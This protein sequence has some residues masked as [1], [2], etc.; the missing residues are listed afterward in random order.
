MPDPAV[1]IIVVAYN[2]PREVPR[3]IRSLSMAMQVG[4]TRDVYEVILVD[5]GSTCKIDI[6]RCRAMDV[7]LRVEE[8]GPGEPSPCRAV[9]RGLAL[10]RGELCG[11]MIDGARL[12]SP[13]LVAGALRA[14]RLH[15]RPVISTLGFHLG[16]DVQMKTVRRGY[17]QNE[18]DRLLARVKWTEDG[19]RLFTISAFA[20]SSAGGWFAPLCE[21]NALFLPKDLWTELGGYDERFRSPGGGLANLDTYVRACALPDSQL[22]TLLGEGTFHQ[23]HGGVATNAAQGA[24]PWQAFHEEYLAIRGR[25]FVKP[26]VIPLFLGFV[27]RHVFRSIAMSVGVA[28]EACTED[29]SQVLRVGESVNMAPEQPGKTAMDSESLN[30]GGMQVRVCPDPVFIIGSPRSGTSALALALDRHSRLWTSAESDFL[31]YLFNNRQAE[32]AFAQAKHGPAQRW[33][34]QEGVEEGE[35]LACL[36]LG[37]NAL[38]TSRSRGRRWLDKSPLYTTIVDVLA[39]LFPGARFLHILRD[40]RRVVHSMIHFA[41]APGVRANKIPKGFIGGWT[42]NFREACRTWRRYVDTAMDFCACNP[43]RGLTVVNEKLLANTQ[44]GFVQICDFLTLPFEEAP[45]EYFRTHRHNSS[46]GRD[47]IGNLPVD[48]GPDPWLEWDENQQAIFLEEAGPTMLRHGLATVQELPVP[49][50]LLPPSADWYSNLVAKIRDRAHAHLAAGLTVAVL[51]K[52]DDD[53]LNLDGLLACH[54]PQGAD[55]SYAGHH[56]ATSAEAIQALEDLRRRGADALLIPATSSWWLDYY[57]EFRQHLES[58]YRRLWA[59]EVCTIF[60]LRVPAVANDRACQT[61]TLS[62]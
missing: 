25:P 8:L 41:N 24:N 2:M 9:N 22:I 21:S 61:G 10:A 16:P 37:L 58:G 19:Y 20:G 53:F 60:D 15:H 18:E 23:V 34:K 46:F 32:K 59:D 44:A 26:D 29:G 39:R 54:F 3:T 33:L 12:A 27:N 4:V 52:G 42:S 31:F 11:V 45:A 49:E 1:S 36:G 35:F 51:S 55:G 47:T 6:E 5:N 56:P 17:D 14:R 38:F 40:G 28:G 13:G 7:C 50:A 30:P 48:S 62:P 57:Q 43:T